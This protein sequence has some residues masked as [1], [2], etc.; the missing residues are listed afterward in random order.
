MAA[1]LTASWMLTEK[2]DFSDWPNIMFIC[3]E[4]IIFRKRSLQQNEQ[5]KVRKSEEMD[6]E[7]WIM[8][9]MSI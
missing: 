7:I 9:D 3:F 4:A 5:A 2:T 1:D 8:F 6:V